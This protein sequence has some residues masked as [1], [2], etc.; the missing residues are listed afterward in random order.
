MSENIMISQKFKR[1]IVSG[2]MEGQKLYKFPNGFGASVVFRRG[3]YGYEQGLCEIGVIRWINGVF[4]LTSGTSLESDI[5]G[6]LDEKERDKVLEDIF[7]L[8][9]AYD[10]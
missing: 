6:F 8:E 7:G 3:S 2:G 10:I 1:Y 9:K 5:F 4:L